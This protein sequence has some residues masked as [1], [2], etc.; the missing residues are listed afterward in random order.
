MTKPFD[1]T[2]EDRSKTLLKRLEEQ[3][4]KPFAEKAAD[5]FI[6]TIQNFFDISASTWGPWEL[7][8]LRDGKPLIDTKALRDSWEK[9]R[10]D[11]GVYEVY[12][13]ASY[14][15]AME[16]GVVTRMTEK[17]RRKLFSLI[18]KEKFNESLLKG[19]SILRIP[20][21]PFARP[22]FELIETRFYHYVQ[23]TFSESF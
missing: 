12:S 19:T 15:A 6:E 17:Q 3:D 8:K 1:F 14:A 10:V 18:P 16:F 13:T 11:E 9:V 7:P 21:R 20:E 4:K 23:S 22:A 5:S 2:F